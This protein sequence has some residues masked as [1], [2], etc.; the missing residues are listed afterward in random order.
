MGESEHPSGERYP[1]NCF[2]DRFDLSTLP[3]ARTAVGY[4][5]QVLDTDTLLDRKTQRFLPVRT[6]GLDALHCSFDSAHRA[7]A[8]WLDT[9]GADPAHHALAIVPVGFDT[10]LARPILIY[11]VICGQP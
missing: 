6:P 4:A 7:A 10:T 9:Q 3:L 8:H 2:G 5:V 1:D 11:G